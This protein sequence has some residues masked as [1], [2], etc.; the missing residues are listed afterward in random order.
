MK[1]TH[2]PLTPKQKSFLRSQAHNLNPVVMLGAA[3]L[4]TA[5]MREIEQAVAHHE[6]IKI[7]LGGADKELRQQLSADICAHTGASAVQ[8]IGRILV[9]YRPAKQPRLK[10]P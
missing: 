5:V 8:C 9:I 3:G 2:T 10:L 6:L 1:P 7:K 4:S